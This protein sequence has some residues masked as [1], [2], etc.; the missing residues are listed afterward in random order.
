MEAAY[1]R[2]L[3]DSP[4]LLE[5]PID[6]P[7]TEARSGDATFHTVAFQSPL[8]TDASADRS[9]VLA[10]FI[11]LLARYSRSEELVIGIPIGHDDYAALRFEGIGAH[12]TFDALA[13]MSAALS[14]QALASN[15]PF[16]QVVDQRR[17]EASG[18][19][20]HPIF[21]A[22]LVMDDDKIQSPSQALCTTQY[23]AVDVVLSVDSNS[24][25]L[26]GRAALFAESTVQRM[27]EH[28]SLLL[29][30]AQQS[31][32]TCVL[33]LNMISEAE[34]T[35]LVHQWNDTEAAWRQDVCIHQLF[36]EQVQALPTQLLYQLPAP[37]LYPL[38]RC[39]NCP[40]HCCISEHIVS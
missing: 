16:S 17:G 18:S 28:L 30:D 10:G 36:E 3:E 23:G 4:P 6:F 29:G 13:E 38:Q 20:I 21:Q 35:Q 34:S 39:T 15:V 27:T 24:W 22:M 19:H 31:G 40:L 7:R 26:H 5:I 32:A 37:L 8:G 1:W 33:A 25:Q 14:Q 11:T 12:T 9:S 2:S